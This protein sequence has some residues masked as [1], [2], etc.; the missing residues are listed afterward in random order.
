MLILCNAPSA[1]AFADITEKFTS[2]LQVGRSFIQADRFTLPELLPQADILITERLTYDMVAAADLLRAVVIPYTGADALP[3]E[4]L[5]E[6]GITLINNHGNS[7]AVAERALALALSLLG[8]IVEMDASLRRGDW[9]RRDVDSET[10]KDQAECDGRF[11]C[12]TSLVGRAVT[13]LGTGSIGCEIARFLKVF[14]CRITGYSRSG[15]LKDSAASGLFSRVT[16]GL[17]EALGQADVIFCALPLT[18]ETRNLI[19]KGN[20]HLLRSKYLINIARGA[21]FEEQSLFDSLVAPAG[22]GL[23]GAA[24]DTWYQYPRPFYAKTHPSRL[25]FHTLSNVILSPHAAS[26]S[27]EGLR[28]QIAEAFRSLEAYLAGDRVE[29]VDLTKGY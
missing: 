14:D 6:R 13:I 16:S 15:T 22:E 21:I 20:I 27:S 4:L 5:A 29:T 12:W 19:H 10:V 11:T 17:E 28:S 2:R 1:L 26:Q 25:P 7:R 24:L 3:L 8:R 18:P 9:G 23:A